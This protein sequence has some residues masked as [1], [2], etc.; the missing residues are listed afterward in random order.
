MATL[1]AVTVFVLEN[2]LLS[3]SRFACPRARSPNTGIKSGP[4]GGETGDFSQPVVDISPGLLSVVFEESV[5]HEGSPFAIYLSGDGDDSPEASC[6]LL[7]HIPHNEQSRYACMHA[8][9]PF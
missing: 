4:C 3:H 6:L 5:S 1:T 7:D 8:S 9:L 2:V